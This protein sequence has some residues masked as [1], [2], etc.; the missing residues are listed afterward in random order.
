M[1]RVDADNEQLFTG[2]S[3]VLS[4][5]KMM[6]KPSRNILFLHSLIRMISTI[7]KNYAGTLPVSSIISTSNAMTVFSLI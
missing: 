2:W 3:C 5:V 6:S 4:R 7:D 1:I